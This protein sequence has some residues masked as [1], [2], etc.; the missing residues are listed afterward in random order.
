MNKLI[1]ICHK[2]N[3]KWNYK[4]KSNYYV[5]CPNCLSKV[6]IKKCGAL[7]PTMFPD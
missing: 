7:V 3:H 2:C 5:T 1:T 6:N 4:G